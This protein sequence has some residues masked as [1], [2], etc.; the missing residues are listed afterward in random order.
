MSG[1][2]V[3]KLRLLHDYLGGYTLWATFLASRRRFF[4]FLSYH[5]LL[6]GRLERING[7]KHAPSDRLFRCFVRHVCACLKLAR[8]AVL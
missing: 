4:L 1:G 2:S 5:P 3:A 8:R 7:G 6:S